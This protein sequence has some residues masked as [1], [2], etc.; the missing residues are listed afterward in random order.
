MTLQKLLEAHVEKAAEAFSY[1]AC[2][3]RGLDPEEIETFKAG[4]NALLP[5]LLA[6][7]DALEKVEMY[8][9][10]NHD[11][12]KDYGEIAKQSLSLIA[13]SLKREG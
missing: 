7:V 12:P 2:H 10:V 6:A 8:A 3:E 13:A 1:Q 11:K 9:R 5:L 4:A